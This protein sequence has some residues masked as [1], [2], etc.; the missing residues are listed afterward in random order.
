MPPAQLKRKL[1]KLLAEKELDIGKILGST[2]A[3]ESMKRLPAKVAASS[4]EVE[5]EDFSHIPF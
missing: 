2:I 5:E 3:W 1:E 4:K